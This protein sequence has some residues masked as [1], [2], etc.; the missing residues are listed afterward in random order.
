[1]DARDSGSMLFG[2]PFLELNSNV[3]VPL[4]GYGRDQSK[5]SFVYQ[6]GTGEET[7]QGAWLALADKTT[8][9]LNG[10]TIRGSTTDLDAD[11]T[12]APPF[13][14]TVGTFLAASYQAT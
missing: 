6:V 5:L 10:A 4:R 9:T 7:P 12:S 11:L 3:R 1:M 2:V 8:I 13:G 14:K